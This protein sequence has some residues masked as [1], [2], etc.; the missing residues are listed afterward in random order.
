MN[1]AYLDFLR[2]KTRIAERRGLDV[3]DSEINPLLKPHQRMMVRWALSGGCRGLFASFGLG[4]SFMQIEFCR[5]VV[6]RV[7]GMGLITI[8]LG[9]RQEFIRDAA[10]LATG[11]HP[12]VT[13]EQRAELRAWQ[14]GRPDRIPKLRF[15]RSIADA[16]DGEL[17][18][19]NY[20]TI[21]DGKLDPRQF[22]VTSL[23]EASCLRGFGGSKTF[24]EF[25]RLFDGVRF[26]LVATATPSPNDYIELLAY[27]AFL[28]IMDV[29]E[30]KTRFFKRNSEKADSLTI[31]PHKEREFWIWVSSWALFVQKPSDLGFDDTGYDLPPLRVHQHRVTTELTTREAERDG[32]G[33]LIRNAAL[34][35]VGASR[36]KRASLTARVAKMVE[37]I[38]AEP[39]EHFLL[40][41]DLEDERRA[42]E[43]A[44]PGVRSVYGTQDLDTREETILGFSDGAFQHLAAKPVIAGSGCNFQRHCNRAVFLGIGFKFNDFIQAVHR[45]Q[46]FMQPHPVDI[47]IISSDGEQEILRTLMMK[48]KQHE[49]MVAEMGKIIR[50]YGLNEHAMAQALARSIGV[51]RVEISGPNHRIVNNDTVLETAALA[52]NSI[53][54][55]VTSIP[56]ST[57]Y[58][59]T[60]SYNDFGH[61]DSDAH[62]WAQMDF[63]TP[64]LLRALSPGRNCVIHVKDRIVPGGINGLG[65]QTVSTFHCDAIQHFRRHGFAFLGMK[66]VTTDVVRENNQTYRLGWSEQC[67]DGSK[68]GAGMPEYLLIFRKPPSDRS[69]SYADKRVTKAKKWFGSAEREAGDDLVEAVDQTGV[70]IDSMPTTADWI[71][72]DGYSRARWQIDAHGYLRSS[73]DRALKADDLVGVP[74]AQ[75]FRMWKRYNLEA[76]YDF[77]FHVA[78]AEALETRGRLPPTFMLL[79]P[80]APTDDHVWSDVT[81]MLTLNGA[82]HA[83]GKEM[84]LCPLQFDIVDRVIAQMSMKGET[85]LDPFGGLMTVPYRAMLLGRKGIGFE[86]N[87]G[88]F[89]DGATYCAAAEERIAIPS[90]FD[91][92]DAEQEPALQ[93]AE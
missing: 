69:N 8:P 93:A 14:A 31:H 71:N 61:T 37:I 6:S 50:E 59:Y 10:A 89:L 73:G 65:F 45:I 42:I 90:L 72:P 16:V 9:V 1:A 68:M 19:S 15:I 13:D 43:A 87:P 63:L 78:I 80:H 39:S 24:R 84:H 17:H 91:L 35:V 2:A 85:V 48:W 47:H 75:I 22:S 28:E 25:M 5:I 3:D 7:G 38:S 12:N 52:E 67:K 23:D 62:F 70:S 41:H 55:I 18:L 33:I 66:T 77:E 36:E 27:S 83:K 57:Q 74:A 30:A 86:L 81:R 26:K 21:R 56:F 11:D 44:V 51:E 76:V 34:G 20:E 82:Q 29:G 32:Q 49:H 60:P 88:Y 4:K 92:L 64:N 46:R 54:L 40:W 58:E 53:D 79:P